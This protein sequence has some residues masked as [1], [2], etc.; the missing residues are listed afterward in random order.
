MKLQLSIIDLLHILFF[1]A[2]LSSWIAVPEKPAGHWNT[3]FFPYAAAEPP[4]EYSDNGRKPPSV[5]H[6]VSFSWT[7]HYENGHELFLVYHQRGWNDAV[8][9]FLNRDYDTF[10]AND[11]VRDLNGAFEMMMNEEW[12]YYHYEYA[13]EL[14]YRDARIEIDKLLKQYNRKELKTQ[15]TEYPN[16]RKHARNA[17]IITLVFGLVTIAR[18]LNIKR[19]HRITN[20]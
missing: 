9:T 4:T 19:K 6:G 5:T 10:V 3:N 17:T 20:G 11:D 15:F 8:G 7:E 16:I 1:V 2:V 12:N 18:Y 14:G 13:S